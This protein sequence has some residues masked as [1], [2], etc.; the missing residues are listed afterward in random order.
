MRTAG[1]TVIEASRGEDALEI[2]RHLS[3]PIDLV[4]SDVVMPGIDGVELAKQLR[5]IQPDLRVLL[6]SGYANRPGTSGRPLPEAAAFLQ[7][8]FG[9]EEL[10]RKVAEVLSESRPTNH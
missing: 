5:L 7:K 8:P 3:Q 9:S 1:H 4:V 10:E 6:V 2:V